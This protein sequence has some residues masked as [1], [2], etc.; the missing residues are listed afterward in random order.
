[1]PK[2]LVYWNVQHFSADKFFA[3]KRRRVGDDQEGWGGNAAFNYRRVLF[4]TITAHNPD[5]IVIVEARPAGNIGE[6]QLLPDPGTMLLLDHLRTYDDNNWALVPPV[7][8]G[9][10][11]A[12]EGIAIFYRRSPTLW[13]T[14]PWRWPG[15][16]GPGVA[17]GRAGLYPAAYRYAF[18]QPIDNRRVPG[19]SRYNGGQMERRLAAQWR[20]RDAFGAVRDFGGL[21]TRSPFRTTFFDSAAG[22]DFQIVAFHAAPGQWGFPGPVNAPSVVATAAAGGLPEVQALHANETTVFVGDFN[23]S[24]FD[25][26]TTGA[27]YANFPAPA[28]RRVITQNAGRAMPTTYPAKGYLITHQMG[29]RQATPS[30]ENGYPAFGYATTEADWYGVYDSIDNAFVRSGAVARATIANIVTGAP[31]NAVAAPRAVPA[32]H[33]AYPSELNDPNTINVP[34]GYDPDGITFDDEVDDFRTIDNYGLVYGV[35]DHLPLVFD[36]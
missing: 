32:G 23:V 20:Y 33:Y 7:I 5:F 12:G 27:A 4:D 31:Y 10:G 24:L 1:M 16:A 15:G 14:G 11:N 35:S 9:L 25:A 26:V 19:G 6:G 30:D 22:Q 17:A 2:K 18:S 36:F 3:R 13:F 29:V 34:N 8:S 21:G 28:W